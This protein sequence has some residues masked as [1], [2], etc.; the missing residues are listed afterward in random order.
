MSTTDRDRERATTKWILIRWFVGI[1]IAGGI[2]WA[3]DTRGA[4][5]Q[6]WAVMI[7]F[8]ILWFWWTLERQAED[9]GEGDP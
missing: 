9:E 7:G 6:S 3:L 5:W 2:R 8:I 4:I 1:P